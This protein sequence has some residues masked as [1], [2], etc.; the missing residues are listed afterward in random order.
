MQGTPYTKEI[1]EQQ[2]NYQK[3]YPSHPYQQEPLLKS[4]DVTLLQQRARRCMQM[5][6]LS[7][8]EARA[9][10]NQ[11]K[12]NTVAELV[13][14]YRDA[15]LASRLDQWATRVKESLITR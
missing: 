13:K 3:R 7:V 6:G 15:E 14:G 9:L 1:L 12:V 4:E 8:L 10:K 11:F 5:L 2:Y